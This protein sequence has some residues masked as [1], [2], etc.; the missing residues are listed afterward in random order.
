MFS[1]CRFLWENLGHSCT[2]SSNRQLRQQH[3][4]HPQ[5]RRQHFTVV[6][7]DGRPVG[8]ARPHA[9]NALPHRP[10]SAPERQAQ[11]DRPLCNVTLVCRHVGRGTSTISS[12]AGAWSI[13]GTSFSTL[14]PVVFFKA[15]QTALTCGEPWRYARVTTVVATP[16]VAEGPFEDQEMWHGHGDGYVTSK[17]QIVHVILLVH[18]GTLSIVRVACRGRLGTQR[19][20]GR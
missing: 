3:F 2:H 14:R 15:P 20:G 10:A 5:F 8:S 6:V 16:F 9:V 13:I 12:G 19:R 4:A 18:S 17:L 11:T 1:S 7:H